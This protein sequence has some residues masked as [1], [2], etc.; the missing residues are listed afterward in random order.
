MRRHNPEVYSFSFGKTFWTGFSEKL[1]RK[2]YSSRKGDFV[3]FDDGE[4]RCLRCGEID[5]VRTLIINLPQF[6][7]IWDKDLLVWKPVWSWQ[8]RCLQT[9]RCFHCDPP[10][11]FEGQAIIQFV[12][13]LP[14]KLLIEKG[15]FLEKK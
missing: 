3:C 14:E 4:M 12:E 7:F 6:F 13:Y 2:L 11:H 10:L 8:R 9:Q 1:L 15:A 5:T